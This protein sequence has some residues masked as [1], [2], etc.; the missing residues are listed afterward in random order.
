VS[1]GR[2]RSL[3]DVPGGNKPARSADAEPDQRQYRQ[4]DQ[5]ALKEMNRVSVRLTDRVSHT[6]TSRATESK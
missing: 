6:A 2:R 5:H 1:F 4:A 3:S